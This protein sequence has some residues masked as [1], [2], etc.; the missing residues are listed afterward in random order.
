MMFGIGYLRSVS[1]LLQKKS[2]ISE[3]IIKAHTEKMKND[4]SISNAFI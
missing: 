1:I 2:S 4:R 3:K